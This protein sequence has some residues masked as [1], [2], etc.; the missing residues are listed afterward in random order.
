MNSL[1]QVEDA[2]HNE[3]VRGP[4]GQWAPQPWTSGDLTRAEPEPV[5]EEPEK[6]WPGPQAGPG[7]VFCGWQKEVPEPGFMATEPGLGVDRLLQ[8]DCP[9]L[10]LAR[11]LAPAA[12]MRGPF[13]AGRL[14][15]EL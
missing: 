14:Q 13:P 10:H 2:V 6:V 8:W 9:H 4:R 15:S 11:G 1:P 7:L 12:Q 5:G 3:A